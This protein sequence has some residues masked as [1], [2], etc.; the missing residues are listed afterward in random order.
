MRTIVTGVDDN[1]VVRDTHIVQ[2]LEQAADGVVVLK[3]SVD[4]FAVAVG[5]AAA[6]PRERA[7]ASASVCH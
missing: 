2:R 4:V 6:T 3:H 7:F 1:G 5:I